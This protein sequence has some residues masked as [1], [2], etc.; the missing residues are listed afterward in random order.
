MFMLKNYDWYF[1]TY[2]SRKYTYAS[3]SPHSLRVANLLSFDNILIPD[4][5]LNLEALQPLRVGSQVPA[6]GH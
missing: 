4:C 6:G 2:A 1:H 3:S 5:S